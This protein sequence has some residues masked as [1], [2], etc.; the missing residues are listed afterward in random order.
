MLHVDRIAVRAGRSGPVLLHDVSLTVAPGCLLAV[1]GPNGSGKSTLLRAIGGELPV[2]RGSIRWKQQH[3]DAWDLYRI[4]RERAFLDQHST[5]P[6]AFTAE[7][8]VMMGRYPYFMSVPSRADHVAVEAAMRIMH[9]EGF[10]GRVMPGMSGGEQQRTHIARVLAQLD[11]RRTGPSLL[12][13]D[14]PLNDLDIVHQHAV[15]Q[16]A[17]DHAEAGNCVVAVIHDVNLAVQ[18]AHRIALMGQGRLLAC[19]SIDE[20]ID[21]ELLSFTYGLPAKVSRHPFLGIPWIHFGPTQATERSIF[22]Q[23]RSKPSIDRSVNVPAQ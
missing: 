17:R 4:A 1:L 12:L 9:L 6:F 22:E 11:D 19:G 15:M 3:I 7:E 20:T 10:R 14:E 18:Y 23:E 16:Q 13:L 2:V 21:E 8:V 5:V